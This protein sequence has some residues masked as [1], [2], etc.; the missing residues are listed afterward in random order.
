MPVAAI[1]ENSAIPVGDSPGLGVTAIRLASGVYRFDDLSE[2]QAVTLCQRYSQFFAN[3]PFPRGPGLAVEMREL[4]HPIPTHP[5]A[6]TVAGEYA[7]ILERTPDQLTVTG[8]NFQAVLQSGEPGRATLAVTP[9][10]DSALINAIEN[11]L[12]VVSA[13]RVLSK[14]GLLLHSA[15]LV[16]DG[17]AYLFAG[18]SGAG[19][20][21]LTSKAH[22]AGA[23]ILSDDINIA[24]PGEDGR[25]RAYPVPFAGDFGQT[26]DRLA[27]GG[28]PLAALCVLEQGG[29]ATLEPLSNAAAA[30]RLVAACPFVNADPDK[31]ADLLEAAA[32]LV[33]QIPVRKLISRREDDFTV[34]RGLLRELTDDR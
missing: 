8:I 14:G 3:S 19:K 29:A 10:P 21:T 20:T 13:Y 5:E 34:I 24:L 23:G 25:L 33:R 15:G 6:F 26:P 11:F 2:A 32:N 27:P 9:G 17:R 28:Y 30:A 7:P 18:Q 4:A 12:R 1:W 16:V 22:A 31:S